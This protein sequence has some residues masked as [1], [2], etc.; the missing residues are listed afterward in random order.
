MADISVIKLP[1]GS[2]YDIKDESAIHSIKTINNESLLGNG[3]ITISNGSNYTAGDGIDITSDIISVDSNLTISGD[4]AYLD[5]AKPQGLTSFGKNLNPF[6]YEMTPASTLPNPNGNF[7]YDIEN[8]IIILN[9]YAST[10]PNYLLHNQDN[11]KLPVGQYILSDGWST[12]NWGGLYLTLKDASNNIIQQDLATTWSGQSQFTITEALYE[13]YDHIELGIYI[14]DNNNYSN[15][16]IYPMIRYAQITSDLWDP[17]R[18][19]IPQEQLVSGINIKT[20]NNSNILGSGNLSVGTVK[21][22]KVNNSSVVNN[23][24]IA[25][26]NLVL[27]KYQNTYTTIDSSTSTV[28]IGIADYSSTD[29]LLVDV[30]GLLLALNEDYTINST[31]KTVTFTSSLEEGITVHFTII[32]IENS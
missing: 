13:Q 20:V 30:N 29:M 8:G 16:T 6:P 15:I 26:I 3:N 11:F 14:N 24:D 27:R 22:V 23:S 4:T 7:R 32:R 28:S 9:G 21:G 25:N 5:Y 18:Q 2:E 1:N 10:A 31:N 17:Y 19:V 12:R